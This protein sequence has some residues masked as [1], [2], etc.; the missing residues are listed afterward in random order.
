MLKNTAA[1]ITF[2]AAVAASAGAEE[3]PLAPG[4][5]LS[6]FFGLDD[7]RR[8]RLR[9]L[10]VCQGDNGR[11][12][13]PVIFSDEIDETTLDPE[14]FQITTQSGKTGPAACVTLR[15]ADDDG[16]RRTVLVIGDL[17]ASQDQPVSVKITG[18][19][20]SL[21]GG[22]NFKGAQS[23]VIPLEAGPTL[24]LAELAP[25]RDW[26]LGG[27][28]N[29]PADNVKQ[30]VRA[31]WTGGVTKPGGGEIDDV[32]RQLYRVVVEGSGGATEAVTP[33]AIGDLNDNDNNHELCLDVDGPPISIF[34]PAG[35]LTDP[36]EDLN[37]DTE[38]AVS[39]PRQ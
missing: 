16:E 19:L 3:A 31:T 6:A 20:I 27:P 26:V 14:D 39:R 9:T 1:L 17:G 25:P 15:P 32:E 7:S 2:V 29:C 22:V 34:F 38:I 37:P 18:D 35:A 33:F 21:N 12:G 23:D 36:N 10:L 8:I 4:R 28:D 24:I 11:D 5:I 13:M 30:I